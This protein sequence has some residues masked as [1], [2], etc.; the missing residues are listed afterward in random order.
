MIGLR[1]SYDVPVGLFCGW[2]G[3]LCFG[4]LRHWPAILAFFVVALL[5]APPVN[6]GEGVKEP[7]RIRVPSRPLTPCA[8]VSVRAGT[9][10]GRT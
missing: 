5:C 1:V 3:R 10:K 6:A 8:K 7:K 9:S 4:L 2:R